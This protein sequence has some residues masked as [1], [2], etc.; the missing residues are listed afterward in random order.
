MI[1]RLAIILI[2]FLFGCSGKAEKHLNDN[3]EHIDNIQSQLLTAKENVISIKKEAEQYNNIVLNGKI[4]DLEIQINTLQSELDL[5]KITNEKAV[6]EYKLE[7]KEFETYKYIFGGL[8][9]ILCLFLATKIN[10][11]KIK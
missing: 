2:F 8:Y 9:F 6:I 3:Q 10:I 11:F 1:K 5:L 7:V 4:N